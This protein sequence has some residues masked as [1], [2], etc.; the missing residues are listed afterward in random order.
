MSADPL[1]IASGENFGVNAINI[2]EIRGIYTG[3]QF[4]LNNNKVI[5]LNLGIDNPLRSKFEQNILN[6]NKETLAQYWLQAHYLGHRAPKVFKSQESVAEFLSKVD[7]SIGY[8]DEEIAQKYHLK[9][10]FRAKE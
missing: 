4:R 2:D 9:I 3:K 5:P 1:V 8:V 6:E 10:L 7:N